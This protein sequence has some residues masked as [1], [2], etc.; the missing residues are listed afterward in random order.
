MMYRERAVV[1]CQKHTKHLNTLCQQEA[2]ILCVNHVIYIYIY[3]VAP[4]EIILF[5][6]W[7]LWNN[8]EAWYIII[9]M[10]SR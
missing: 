6:L 5:A 10:L 9:P 2:D 4:Q 7:I 8:V 1:Y 3:V